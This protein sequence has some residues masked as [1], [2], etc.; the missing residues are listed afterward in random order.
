MI[1][2]LLLN[3]GG[4]ASSLSVWLTPA[5]CPQPDAPQASLT[6]LQ[7]FK[8]K[9]IKQHILKAFRIGEGKGTF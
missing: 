4:W 6:I 8:T 9:V 1:T 5:L 3:V 2:N 7:S